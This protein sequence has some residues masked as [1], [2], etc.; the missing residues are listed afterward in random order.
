MID[1]PGIFFRLEGHEPVACSSDD[2]FEAFENREVA[3][4]ELRNVLVST[5][6]LGIAMHT[7]SGRRPWLFET[8]VFGG[9][10]DRSQERYCTWD[11]AV[12][13]HAAWLA[14]V[15]DEDPTACEGGND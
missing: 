4:T 2:W 13:G 14:R 12:A 3:R 5:I 10:L 6:F 7:F 8:M 1:F 15:I 9:T 11:E